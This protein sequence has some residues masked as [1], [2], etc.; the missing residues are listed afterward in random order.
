MAKKKVIVIGAGLAG[1]A[2][3]IYARMNGYDARIFEHGRQP[4]GVSATWKRGDYLFDGGIHFYMG[5]RPGQPVHE[6]YQELGVYQADQY[7]EMDIYS[8]F[9]HPQDGSSIDVTPDLDGFAAALRDLSPPDSGLVGDLIAGAKT[10]ARADFL[11][12]MEKPPEMQSAWGLAKMMFRAAR[13]LKYYR[14]RYNRPISATT[15]HMQHPWLQEIW[16]HIFLPDVPVW[17]VLV[18]LGMLH[19]GNMA[20][21]L[22]GSAGFAR[23]LE[24]R[25]LD[26][27]GDITYGATV[28]GIRVENNRAVG[29]RLARGEDH[30]SDIVVSAADGYQTIF[31]LLSGRYLNADIRKRFSEWPLFK[32]VVMVNFGVRREFDNDPWMVSAKADPPIRAGFPASDWMP[33]RIFNY[34]S[35]FAPAGRTVLQVMI[36]SAWN[37]WSAL[38]EDMPAY[39]A[40]KKELE[41]QVLKSLE[42]IWPGLPDQV[43]V[44]DVSTPCTLW[45]YTLNR[46]GAYEGFALTEKTITA[47]VSRTLPGLQRFYM[48]GQWTTPGGGVV[49]SLMTGRH[50]VMLMCRQDGKKFR[51]IE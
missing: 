17:F 25:F 37:P 36:E 9:I 38:R 20:L 12:P 23:A 42:K 6:L 49:P 27:G 32:P 22:D 44:S 39:R 41:Q 31:E 29:V 34:S 30:R 51:R 15:S 45:R 28:T 35:T 14:G 33:V 10:F 26:L 19:A 18:I 7:R 48:A 4:G 16:D 3:G 13:T 43:E 21:R 47:R 11:A 24:Q 46:R 8:R 5:F 2:T 1:L 40:E 50:A